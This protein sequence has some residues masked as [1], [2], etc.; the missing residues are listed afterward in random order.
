MGGEGEGG[1]NGGVGRLF[2]KFEEYIKER[3]ERAR[4][5]ARK[6]G[7]RSRGGGAG[8]GGGDGPAFINQAS[9]SILFKCNPLPRPPPPPYHHPYL[10]PLLISHPTPPR[11]PSSPHLSFIPFCL[12]LLL[13]LLSLIF[14]FHLANTSKC[15]RLFF[16]EPL[17]RRAAAGLLPP[18]DEYFNFMLIA[19]SL[20]RCLAGCL[21]G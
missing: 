4:Q 7:K 6:S 17:R 10:L 11:A 13:L 1:K 16:P 5:R 8:C 12:L 18:A 2:C 14:I 15:Y 19:S 9:G 20:A 21:A 3:S